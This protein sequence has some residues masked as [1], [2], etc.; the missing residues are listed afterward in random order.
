MRP[1]GRFDAHGRAQIDVIFLESVRPHLA[2]PIQIIGQPLFKRAL[3]T[4][5]FREIDVIRNAIVNAHVI[6]DCG[7]KEGSRE[8]GVGSGE[9]GK[10]VSTRHA[11]PDSAPPTPYSP[12]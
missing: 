8:W 3:Q 6:T 1:A 4:R 7:L 5:V 10:D 9:W 12:L 11:I 2:P